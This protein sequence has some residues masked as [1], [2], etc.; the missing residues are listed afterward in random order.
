MRPKVY[1]IILNW[2]GWQDTLE[3]L[4]SVKKINYQNYRMIVIDNGSTNES[5]EKISGYIKEFKNF[6]LLVQKEN[7][8]FTGGNNL[9]I[10]YALEN[11]ADYVLL[12]NND[13]TV[14]ENFLSELAVAAE[15][16]KTAGL[17][18][19]KI[20]FYNNPKK[21]W[22][23]GGNISPY[24]I[25]GTH[26][27]LNETD[28]GQHDLV[29]KADYLTGCCLLIKKETI[30]K[31]GFLDEDY[32][33]YYEDTDYSWRARKAG[34]DCVF[35]PQSKIWHKCSAVAGE[36][37]LSYIYYHTRNGLAL[38]R[39]NGSYSARLFLHFKVVA[40]LGK[41]IFKLIFS[42]SKRIWVK[43]ILLGIEDFYLGRMGNYA[44]WH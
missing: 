22:F 23:A 7:L 32:F 15:K 1:I 26:I 3:C 10:K 27:G 40:K 20:Y 24:A 43:G 42:P 44:N 8:G 19:P 25:K 5:V 12:L 11:G 4:E 28:N 35:V 30:D 39:K 14:D 34:L 38:I 9:G 29:K 21:I 41:Q 33:L 16:F 18:G 2:N 17:L 6:E 31:I 37:S 13:T 36:G